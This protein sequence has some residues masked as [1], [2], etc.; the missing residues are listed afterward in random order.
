MGVMRSRVDQNQRE[1]VEHLRAL[2]ASVQILSA[3]GKGCPDILVGYRGDNHLMEIKSGKAS[4]TPDEGS[5]FANWAGR[6]A[7]VRTIEDAEKVI[8]VETSGT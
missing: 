3:V 7:I 6:V 4:L 2:G 8:G 1:I 5:W